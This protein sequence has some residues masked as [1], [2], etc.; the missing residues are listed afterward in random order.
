M[1]YI[2]S[3][4]NLY[5]NE[6]STYDAV[7]RKHLHKNTHETGKGILNAK[8]FA[9]TFYVTLNVYLKKNPYTLT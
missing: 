6:P 9:F 2:F 8:C 7:A 4:Q 5:P 3:L 1:M